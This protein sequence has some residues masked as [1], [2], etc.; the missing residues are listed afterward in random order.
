M[1]SLG[2]MYLLYER[3]CTQRHVAGLDDGVIIGI[4]LLLFVETK[5]SFPLSILW[6]TEHNLSPGT[7]DIVGWAGLSIPPRIRQDTRNIGVSVRVG[8][9]D[10]AIK[11]KEDAQTLFVIF[12]QMIGMGINHCNGLDKSMP[13]FHAWGLLVG[14]QG[15]VRHDIAGRSLGGHGDMTHGLPLWPHPLLMK[16]GHAHENLLK[17]L[18]V[19]IQFLFLL[20]VH[21]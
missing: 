19:R 15:N 6:Q 1:K 3:N 2:G 18:H 7:I 11:G 16:L 5:S 10:T 8:T 9:R 21:G 13:Y 17:L 14:L 4:F 20:T 12:R